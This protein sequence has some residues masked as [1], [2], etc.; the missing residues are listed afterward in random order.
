MLAG[1]G[2]TVLRV[3]TL[4]TRL[5]AT[6]GELRS[7]LGG[8]A[9]LVVTGCAPLGLLRVAVRQGEPALLA[10]AIERLRAFVAA[11]DGSVVVERGAAAL[12][13]SVDPWGPAPPPA[14]ELMRALKQQ[15]D[16]RRTL[17]PGRFAGGI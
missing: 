11:D 14:L 10:K 3:T 8:A 7:A 5:A 2:A 16:P 1:T 12:R 17:N 6:L 4:T 13:S 9:N 15:F